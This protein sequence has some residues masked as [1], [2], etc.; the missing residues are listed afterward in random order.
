M[1]H[2]T[3]ALSLCGLCAGCIDYELKM[4]GAGGGVSIEEML[5][6]AVEQVDTW[7]ASRKH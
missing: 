5:R 2:F 4:F 7:D 1:N 3:P 6:G